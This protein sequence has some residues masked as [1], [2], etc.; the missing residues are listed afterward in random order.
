LFSGEAE[1]KMK[2]TAKAI[3]VVTIIMLISRFLPLVS[4]SLYHAWYYKVDRLQIYSYV[5]QIPNIIFNSFGTV[6]ATIIIPVFAGY[7]SAGD[8]KRAFRY[9][10]NMISISVV[11]TVALSLLCM[12][13]APLILNF[14]P[15]FKSEDYDF[16]VFALRVM[17]P[18]MI[19]YALNYIFQGILQSFGRF[20]MPAFVSIPSSLI[21][22]VYI[23]IW[24]HSYGVWGLVIATFVGLST[25]ALI[26]IPPIF[27]TE[28]RFRPSLNLKDEDIVK[29]MKL[30][31]PILIGTSAYQVNMLFNTSFASSYKDTVSIMIYAQSLVINIVL[32]FVFSVTAVVFPKF[33]VFVTNNDMQGLKTSLMKILRS[34]LYLLIPCTAGFIA[35][36]Y[37]L[38]GLLLDWGKVD[39]NGVEMAAGMMALYA[40]GICGIGIKEVVDRVFYS[41]K[42]TVSPTI[43]GVIIMVVNI[44]AG[45][46]LMR[47]IRQYG[48][49]LAYSISSLF[50]MFVL[51]YLLR[52]KI[53]SLGY[54]NLAIYA[55]KII[56]A[57]G[58]MFLAVLG[59][60]VLLE[61]YTF[62]F[63][64]LDRCVKLFI[65]VGVG[66]A[67]YF[68]ITYLLRIDEAVEVLNKAKS[69]FVKGKA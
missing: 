20:N 54:R 50:G 33:T 17:F 57:S 18:I 62:G 30:V 25:Q 64:F 55:V 67:V 12:I 48:I 39:K 37:Q 36:R 24:G 69:F 40:V 38:A 27:K 44:T 58:I 32:A 8:K 51:L 22:I 34:L 65:P 29:A 56:T 35:V 21:V 9:A 66:S 11:F 3:G 19:F 15:S 14:V 23:L 68:V 52:R 4:S 49:T 6:L 13:A 47:F 26:L 43:N 31:P 5:I 1:G 42:D 53:G 46:I 45:L 59:T 2:S 16:A 61:N 7:L 28:Y 41:L 10:D 60:N 63:S